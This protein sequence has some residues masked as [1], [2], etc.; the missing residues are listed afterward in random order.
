MV[1]GEILVKVKPDTKDLDKDLKKKRKVSLIPDFGGFNIKKS[2]GLDKIFGKISGGAG[3][4][5]GAVV[6]KGKKEEGGGFLG[7]IKALGPLALIAAAVSSLDFVLKPVM[8]LFKAIIALLFIPLIP[9][10][11]PALKIIS[12]FIPILANVMNKVKDFVAK[13]VNIL[14][15]GISWIWENILQPIWKGLMVAFEIIFTAGKWIWDNI[16]VPG[17]KILLTIGKFIWDFIVGAFEII[18]EIGLF[19]WNLI[20][21]GFSFWSDIGVKLWD[22]I[23]SLFEGTISVISKVW[24][25]IKGFFKGSIEVGKSVWDFIKSLFEGTI[26]VASTVWSWFKGLFSGKGKSNDETSVE[27]AIIRPNGQIIRT[28]PRDTLIATQNP[29]ALVNGA[30][31]SS[32][33]QTISISATINNDMDIRSLAVRLAELSK[34]ELAMSTGS[35]RF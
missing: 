3:S 26:N 18:G 15:D 12:K 33:T 34:D 23:K 21:D 9:I 1:T 2:L 11:I 28:D 5:G 35:Q 30:G 6:G 22:F 19:L 17:F 29:G 8:A 31:G 16:I 4:G 25:F 24:E 7:I 13:F 10:F 27:D 20:K 14:G 32:V